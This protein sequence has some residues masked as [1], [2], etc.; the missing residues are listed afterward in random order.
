MIYTA[1]R[2]TV[3]PQMNCRWEDFDAAETVNIDYIFD[4]GSGHLPKTQARLLHDDHNIYGIYK[5]EDQFIRVV[6]CDYNTNI[7]TDSCVEFFFKPFAAKGYFNLEMNAGA[8]HLLY[9]T[10]D[11]E[12]NNKNDAEGRVK[13]PREDGMQVKIKTTLPSR[14]EPEI[15]EPTTWFL[16]F[17]IPTEML[18]KYCGPIGNLNGQ[19]WTCNFYKCGDDTSHPHW[20]AWAP[21]TG[22]SFHQPDKFQTLVL[23]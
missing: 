6:N 19:K 17:M 9:Y 18:A 13:L 2:T 21:L 20:L 15:Q 11:I 3:P 7:W 4:K 8:H 23:E 22:T 16:Q 14:V 5:V 10:W 1:K 12:A